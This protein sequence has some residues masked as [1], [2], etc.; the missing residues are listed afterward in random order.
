MNHL[1]KII[2]NRDGT[3][4]LLLDIMRALDIYVI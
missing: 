1:F 3:A 4:K 2:E